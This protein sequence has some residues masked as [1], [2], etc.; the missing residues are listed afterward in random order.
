MKFFVTGG[1]G[2]IGRI[3]CRTLVA[4]GDEVVVLS[5]KGGLLIPGVEVIIGDISDWGRKLPPLLSDKLH[6]RTQCRNKDVRV[7]C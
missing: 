1:S 6:G 5:R 2:F 3:L 7:A 4:R